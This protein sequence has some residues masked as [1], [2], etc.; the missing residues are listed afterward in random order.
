MSDE[1]DDQPERVVLPFRKPT[2]WPHA[3]KSKNSWHGGGWNAPREWTGAPRVLISN[4]SAG[5]TDDD[6][7]PPPPMAA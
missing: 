2:G 5:G 7:Q 3:W 4:R 6:D 1:T